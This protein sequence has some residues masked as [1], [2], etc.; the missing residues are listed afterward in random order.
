[1][2]KTVADTFAS[3][4][5]PAA[6]MLKQVR[7]L[8]LSTADEL[9]INKVEETLKWGE[10]SYLVKGGSTLRIAWK[11]KS[12]DQVSMYFHCQTRLVETFREIHPGTFE[13]D[14]KRAIHLPLGKKY[15]KAALRQCIQM[16]LTYHKVKHLPL[17][18][19]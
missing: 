11:E 7:E 18:G 17:L 9:G 3:Y 2:D 10:P 4:P 6:K 15:S 13:Y 16:A 19:A 5:G 1:M 12:P 8:I 14:G